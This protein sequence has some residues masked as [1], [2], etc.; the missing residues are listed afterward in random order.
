[1]I[2]KVKVKPNS[3]KEEINKVSEN[4]Y[5]IYVGEEAENNKANIRVVNLL[6]KEF[7]VSFRDIKIINKRSKDKLIEIKEN[8]DN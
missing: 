3:K 2:I 5:E 8:S 1:M 4:E 6:A 7:D